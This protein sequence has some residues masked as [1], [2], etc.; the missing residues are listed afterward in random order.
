VEAVHRETEGNPFFVHEVVQLLQSDG[1]LERAEEVESWSLEIP[2][3]VRQVVGRR[4]SSLSE[5]CNG[6]LAVA[7]VI[8]REFELPVLARVG[9]LGEDAALELLEQAE[10]ARIVGELPDTSGSYRFSHA[11][12][13]ETLYEEIRTT[14]RLRL[15]RR[16]AEAIETLHAAKLEPRLAELAYHYCEAASGGDVTKAVDYA[17]RAAERETGLLA[18]EEAAN[19]YERALTALDASEPVD[20]SRRCELLIALGEAQFCSGAVGFQQ[21]FQRAIELARKIEAPE[22]FARAA[23][24]VAAVWVQPAGLVDE[25][26]VRVLEEALALLGDEESGLRARLMARLASE[27]LWSEE[28]ERSESLCRK[29]IAMAKKVGDRAALARVLTIASWV[30]GAS[31]DPKAPLAITDEIVAIAQESG[32]KYAEFAG[33]VVRIRHLIELGEADAIDREIEIISRLTEELRQSSS[34]GAAARARAARAIWRGQLAEARRLSWEARA[35]SLRTAPELTPQ[36]FGLQIYCMRRQQGRIGETLPMLRAGLKRF[37]E[38]PVWRCLLACAHVER[39]CAE[40]A[41]PEFEKLAANDFAVLRRDINYLFNLGLLADTCAALRD[42]K[43]AALLYDRILSYGGCVL[44]LGDL[45]TAGSSARSL[46]LLAATMRRWDDAVRHFEEAIEVDEKMRARGWLP[47]TQCDYARMLL[48]RGAPADR[49]KALELLGEALETCQ[50]LGLKG[51]LDMCLELKLRAQGVESSSALASIDVVAS[52]VGERRPDL[53]PHVAPDGT[54][55]LMFSDMEGFTAMTERLGDLEAREVIRRHN[56]VVRE[57]LSAHGGYEV[58][59]QGD[60]FL[61][62]FSSARSA[63]LCAIAIQRA[64]AAYSEAH[65]DEPIRVRIGLHTGEALKDADKFFGK[66]VILAARIASVAR[67]GEILASSLLKELTESTGD[68]RFGAAREVDLKGL[69]ERQRVHAVEW[70]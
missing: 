23:L 53:A 26:A 63:L 39:G 2:Q 36:T 61:L 22:Q 29:A 66:T 69:S 20:E 68:L 60:G 8:G 12:I 40:D 55:T 70:E 64:F 44:A 52:S 37:R 6:L 9:E 3:G 21:S 33:R 28:P 11:L 34:Q 7:S 17:V 30:L 65:P 27:L 4:L 24:G 13:R 42:E 49:Q 54:V 19:Q 25:R 15:H 10:D 57:Q 48:D 46:G 50:E 38:N 62:A 31:E 35:L 59:L 67:G 45:G 14:R 47:R 1:R 56:A 58:E 43:R 18:Y 41:R 32:D 51:W 5:E 16:I